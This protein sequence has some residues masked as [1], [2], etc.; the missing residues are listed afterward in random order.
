MSSPHRLTG[1]PQRLFCALI[2]RSSVLNA[3]P[4]RKYSKQGKEGKEVEFAKHFALK[5]SE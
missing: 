5:L 4:E 2:V 3:G 1:T